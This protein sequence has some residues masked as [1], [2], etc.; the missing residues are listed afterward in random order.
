[1][2][3]RDIEAAISGSAEQTDASQNGEAPA[4]AA[5]VVLSTG[6]SGQAEYQ[7]LMDPAAKSLADALRITYRLLQVAIVL[8]IVV[9]FASGFQTVGEE[10]RALRTTFGRVVNPNVG[11]GPQP[12]WPAPIGELVRIQISPPSLEINEAFWPFIPP[13]QRGIPISQMAGAG[14]MDLNPEQDGSLLTADQGIV[15]TRWRASYRRSDPRR[16]AENLDVQAEQKLV[17]SL[18]RRAIIHAASE[19]TIDEILKNATASTRQDAL[20]T[21]EDRALNRAQSAI[22]RLDIGLRIE[23]LT[24][25]ARIPPLR[26]M[27]EF[28][29]VQGAEAEANNLLEQARS[30]RRTKLTETAGGSAGLLL[31]LIDRYD[32]QLAEGDRRSAVETLARIDAAFRNQPIELDGRAITPQVFGRASTVLSDAGRERESLVRRTQARADIFSAKL[33]AFRVNPGIVLTDEWTRAMQSV[34]GD[35]ELISYV[36][37]PGTRPIIFL[38]PDQ[39]IRRERERSRNLEEAERAQR[40][41]ERRRLEG[42]FEEDVQTRSAPVNE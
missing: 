30:Y 27:P 37:A 11:P 14:G 19:L 34:L 31:T 17:E 39:R 8:L 23:T 15:H 18:I 22:D 10:E 7:A 20:G 12:S 21:I 35:G 24:M 9:F 3:E 38:D 36:L 33:E 28:D 40:E 41:A 1:M 13:N 2:N 42:R 16:Y 32:A 26:T 29:L 4:R 5:S 6:T 25:D